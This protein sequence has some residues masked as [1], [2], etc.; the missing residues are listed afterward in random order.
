MI[1]WMHRLS[2]SWVATL[3]MGGLA[4]SFMVWGIAD[5]FT[6]GGSTAV[7]TVGGSDIDMAGFQRAYRNFIRGESERSGTEITPDMAQKMGLP[8]SVLRQLISRQAVTNAA[9][10]MHLA[11]PQDTLI[12]YVHSQP[13][14][15]APNG[16]FDYGLFQRAVS[17][18]GYS[19]QDYLNEVR[20]QMLSD[21][22]FGALQSGFV[23]PDGYTKALYLYVTERRAAD[24]ILLGP[25]AAGP[26]PTPTDA[27][28]NAYIKAN[29]GQFSTP[30]YRTID[31][32]KIGPADIAAEVNVTEAQIAQEY[33][34]KKATYV[35]PEKREVQQIEFTTIADA[36]AARAKLEKGESFD[37]LAA[38]KKIKPADLS[39]GLQA[40]SDLGER[41]DAVFALKEGEVSQPIKG[42]LGGFVLVRVTKI[43]PGINHPLSEVH[44]AIKKDLSLQLA[45]AK[46]VDVANAFEDARSGGAD[47]A[48]AAKKTG[49]KF[50]HIAAMDKNGNGPD[51]Q[52]IADLP[53]DPEFLTQA[54]AVEEGEDNDPFQAKSGEY[55][56]IKA[57]GRIPAK[58]KTLDQVR[59][60][61][62]AAWVKDR[63][64][65]ALA[66]RASELATQAQ[67]DKS[68]AGIAQSMKVSVLHSAG[69]GRKGGEPAF[70]DSLVQ[71]LFSLRPGGVALGE[72][73]GRVIIALL[74]GISHDLPPAAQM[75]MPASQQQLAQQTAQDL[76]IGFESAAQLQQGTKIDQRN[77]QSAVGGNQ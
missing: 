7:A 77:L 27:D 20:M 22:I 44:D 59:A 12:A 42:A 39:L 38:E 64:G 53:A 74:T 14:F 16:Q 54:F 69:F 43:V 62:S 40:Q 61:A 17:G 2:Q 11:V 67:K 57:T 34:A 32:A 49:M 76:G 4:L 65:Q 3:L 50:A 70:P 58:L 28:L 37:Q 55:Y 41:G 1:Q 45:A 66:K 8:N 46:L 33:T 31:Y 21:Q 72:Q 26:A 71:R 56:A 47:L 5:V 18:A 13:G 60:E 73:N 30:E 63:Q 23:L 6:G 9:E 51:G 19:E 68:L 25:D 36:N 75:A 48:G 29:P 10:R 52:K 35:V 24:Y 15:L